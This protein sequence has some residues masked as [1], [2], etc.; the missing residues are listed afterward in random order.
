MMLE[1]IPLAKYPLLAQLRDRRKAQGLI[2]D[3][4]AEEI[5]VSPT[6]LGQWERGVRAPTFFN[7]CAWVQALD[8][9]LSLGPKEKGA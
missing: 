7:L 5:G 2:I 4:L 6:I 3:E 9:E 1:Y 8:L